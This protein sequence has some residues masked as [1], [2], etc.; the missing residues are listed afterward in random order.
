MTGTTRRRLMLVALLG[1]MVLWLWQCTS[2]FDR[3][4]QGEAI[5]VFGPWLGDDAEAFAAV[6]AD[7]T[8]RTGIQVHY[9]GS[10]DFDSDLRQ[11]ITRGIGLPEVAVIPQPGLIAELYARNLISPLADDTIDAIVENYPFTRQDLAPDGIA[12]LMPYRTN[13]KSLVWFRPDV[14][15][16]HDWAV[17]DT[18]DGLHDLVDEI[19]E[20]DIAPWCFTI[21]AG[22]STGWA[23]SDWIED[24][25]LR[26]AGPETYEQWMLGALAF[27]DEGVREAV[28]EFD[29]LVLAPG[30]TVGGA[31]R[32]L[33]ERVEDAA[34][35]L[36]D[37]PPGCAMYRQA[38]F[39]TNWFPDGTD[40][41]PDGDVD[42]F[43][44][45]GTNADPA[46]LLRGGDGLIQFIDRE[47]VDRLMTF[48]A[49]PDGADAW[50]E[51]GGY[52]SNRDT[53]EIDDYAEA[54]RPF[55]ELLHERRTER[56]DASD[57]FLSEIR[58]AWLASI[59]SFI[60]DTGRLDDLAG[61]DD[62]LA[63]VDQ[64]RLDLI[65][66]LQA[67]PSEDLGID[68]DAANTGDDVG[69]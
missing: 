8:D 53:I 50:I 20:S 44:L 30:R 15:E 43:V 54:D 16:E 63:S 38:N 9:T 68:A 29:E 60:A 26:R 21:A 24:L 41:G 65:A 13:V 31:Q 49:G 37:D 23:A 25:M 32:I 52:I 28:A 10:N 57:S 5:D 61:L 40:V 27:T 39:A 67:A 64:V 56:F 18:L 6:L 58:D 69:G 19:G 42:F 3:G 7:F 62:L 34:G 1:A 2:A 36:F 12:F 11:R 59:T 66:E 48:L 17:P 45:P 14:F 35:P 55:V 22:S 4:E 33:G 51:R 46:P 47:E